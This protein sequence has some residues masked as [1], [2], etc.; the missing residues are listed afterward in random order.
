[1]NLLKE[2]KILDCGED[3]ISSK[4]SLRLREM[5]AHVIRLTDRKKGDPLRSRSQFGQFIDGDSVESIVQCRGKELQTVDSEEAFRKCLS[6]ADVVIYGHGDCFWK[7]YGLSEEDLKADFPRLIAA[8]YSAYGSHSSAADKV[9][10]LLAQASSGIMSLTGNDDDSPMAMGAMVGSV[11]CASHLAQGI[12]LA[13]YARANDGV[14]RRVSVSLL[15]SLLA[16]EFEVITTSINSDFLQPKRAKR[17]NAHS[18]LP[19]P[20]GVYRTKDAYF[21]MSTFPAPQLAEMMGADLPEEY[22]ERPAW[23]ARRDEIMAFFA[24]LFLLRTSQEWLD[25]FEPADIW[26]SKILS[27]SDILQHEGYRVLDMERTLLLP[28]GET[29]HTTACPYHIEVSEEQSPPSL[30]PKAC[31][32]GGKPLEGVLVVDLSQFLSGPSATLQLADFGA[33]VIKIERP[34]VGDTGRGVVI[35]DVLMDG[36]SSGFLSISRNKQSIVADLKN[37]ADKA[38]VLRLVEQADILVQNFRPAAIRRLGLDYESV[39]RINPQIVYAEIS[40]YGQRGCWVNKPGQ[41]FIVQALSGVCHLS[42][43]SREGDPVPMGLSV[44]DMLAGAQLVEGVMASLFNARMRGQGA[45]V[46]LTMLGSSV[47][48]QSDLITAHYRDSSCRQTTTYASRVRRTLDGHIAL[49][50]NVDETFE[51]K[52]TAAA[53]LLLESQGV[54]CAPVLTWQALFASERGQAADMLQRVKRS[55]GYEYLTTRCPIRIEN[56]QLRS[57]MGAPMVGEHTE[58]VLKKYNL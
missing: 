55:S 25:L 47:D 33:T 44:V 35:A 56:T 36:E 1:M 39:K 54:A 42:G 20:Y 6:A 2:I 7:Q 51:D 49:G 40:G 15:E 43:K 34:I 16:I 28:N 26:C 32:T 24:P 22:R 46:L 17:G 21:A 13:L 12:L 50:E 57:P 11:F 27:L 41:D 30:L 38:K 31:S 23:F 45:H 5:G 3:A 10:E 19:A 9:D 18:Y 4:A 29:L 48:L 58:E 53:C 8:E 37:E 14:A 52:T